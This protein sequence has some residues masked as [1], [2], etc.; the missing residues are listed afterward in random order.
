MKTV[1]I[2]YEDGHQTPHV[3][4]IDWSS[5]NLGMINND[6]KIPTEY[7]FDGRATDAVSN[8]CSQLLNYL[9]LPS[10]IPIK[11]ATKNSNVVIIGKGQLQVKVEEGGMATIDNVYYCP[12]AM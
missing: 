12:K 2:G 7:L 3:L 9:P 1:E 6:N 5:E 8:D 11:T 4:A 10:P